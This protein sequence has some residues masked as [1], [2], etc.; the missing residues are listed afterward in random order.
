VGHETDFTICDFVADRRAATPTMAA[1][2]AVPLGDEVAA[3]LDGAL[4]RLRQSME[5]R[6][7]L[8]SGHLRELLRSYALGRIRNRIEGAMQSLDF[9]METLH[10]NISDACR[11]HRT[12]LN[13][14]SARL[15]ALNPRAILSR[16]YTFCSDTASGEVIRSAAAAA[17][18]EEM[19]VSFHDGSLRTEIKERLDGQD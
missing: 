12:S 2:I 10:R 1:E 8:A 6:H 19:R 15:A 13:E 9:S 16:G 4:E 17:E 14:A 7:R 18:L 3:G 5:N 11:G